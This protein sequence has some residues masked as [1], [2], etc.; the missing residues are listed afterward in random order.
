MA[1]W[2]T[3]AW[4]ISHTDCKGLY[5]VGFDLGRL[6]NSEEC[7]GN[8]V[9]PR[10][11]KSP[12]DFIS[13]HMR[14]LESEYVSLHLHHWVDLIFGYKQKGPAAVNALNVFYYTTYEGNGGFQLRILHFINLLS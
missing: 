2:A 11:A 8:V 7:V 9:L 4:W 5:F 14:A 6:Q 13:K 1:W 12:E 10:W 3:N